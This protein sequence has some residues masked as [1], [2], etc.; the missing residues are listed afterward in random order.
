MLWSDWLT[1]YWKDLRSLEIV[2]VVRFE[3]VVF[4]NQL[5][6]HVFAVCTRT[7]VEFSIDATQHSTS[8]SLATIIWCR[9]V[10]SVL[11]RWRFLKCYHGVTLQWSCACRIIMLHLGYLA[12]GD[13][14]NHNVT[15]ETY[16][17]N[18][19]HRYSVLDANADLYVPSFRIY[20][21]YSIFDHFQSNI[22]INQYRLDLLVLQGTQ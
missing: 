10:T 6:T 8:V 15:C 5:L 7:R 22:L 18:N 2:M 13:R 21:V 20:N 9:E 17:I 3:S 11:L 19:C 14:Q 16:P 1:R 4:I 12:K